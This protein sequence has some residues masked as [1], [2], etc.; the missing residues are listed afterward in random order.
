MRYKFSRGEEI[1]YTSYNWLDEISEY[2]D[3]AYFVR[4][5]DGHRHRR[6]IWKSIIFKTKVMG[7]LW[8]M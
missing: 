7:A 5:Q 2:M 3:S 4:Y 8:N 6:L 1:G